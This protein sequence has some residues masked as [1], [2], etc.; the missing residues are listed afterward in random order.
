MRFL[1]QTTGLLLAAL[2]AQCAFGQELRGRVQGVVSDSSGSVIVG[3]AV[4]LKNDNTGVAEK[5]ETGGAGQ[6]LFDFVNPGTYS[7][8]VSLQ[9]FRT[10]VQQ[11]VLVQTRA[12]I[13]VNAAMELGQ[14]SEKITVTELMKFIPGPD[15]PT[16][17]LLYRYRVNVNYAPKI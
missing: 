16:G 9:G 4:T 5:K 2:A 8:T 7:L 1:V 10:F 15:L 14:V 13:T 3:A 12:D 17:G 11:N 6:Y